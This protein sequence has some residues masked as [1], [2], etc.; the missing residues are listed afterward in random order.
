MT[1]KKNDALIKPFRVAKYTA[2]RTKRR[3]RR[4]ARRSLRWVRRKINR[5]RPPALVEAAWSQEIRVA[6]YVGANLNIIDGSSVWTQ[7]T[8]EALHADSR[9][10]IVMPLRFGDMRPVITGSLRSLDRVALVDSTWFRTYRSMSSEEAI[11]AIRWLDELRRFDVVILRG[12][13]LCLTA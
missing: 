6:F 13:E 10:G 3:L 8:A 12:Y 2:L 7:S 9:L 5:P 1:T 11:D 4:A